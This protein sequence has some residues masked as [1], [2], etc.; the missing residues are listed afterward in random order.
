MGGE[1]GGWELYRSFLEVVRRGTLSGAAR[2]LGLTQPTV[3]RHIA[4][5]ESS[6]GLALFTRSPSGLRPTEVALDLVPHAETMSAA[7]A[8][9]A[10]AASGETAEERGTVRITASEVVGVEVLPP[11]VAALRAAHPKIA[12]ELT[13]TN[14]TEDL[15]LREADIAVRMVKP[16]QSAL[17][18]RRIGETPI[19]LFASAGYLARAGTPRSLD[20]LAGHTLIGHDAYP[21]IRQGLASRGIPVTRE[22]FQV[23]TDNEVAQIALVRA[24][25]GIGGM[26][27]PLARRSPDLEPVLHDTISIPMEMWLVMHEDLRTVRRVRLV[28]EQLVRGLSAYVSG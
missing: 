17:V 19:R 27:V 21:R 10:R 23:R 5:L 14:R 25:A 12:V 9:L 6:L 8:A 4:A 18:A 24:G 15:L 20:E 7:A 2:A 11:I 28:H 16:E 22:T 1:S 13:L 3:G 26:P